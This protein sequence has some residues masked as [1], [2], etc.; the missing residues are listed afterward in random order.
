MI[1]MGLGCLFPVHRRQDFSYDLGASSCCKVG[2]GVNFKY[3]L[4]PGGKVR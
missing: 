1:V 2:T 3:E 4:D